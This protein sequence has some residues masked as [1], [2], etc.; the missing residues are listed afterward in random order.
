M[1]ACTHARIHYCHV[2]YIKFSF[3]IRIQCTVLPERTKKKKTKKAPCMEKNIWDERKFHKMRIQW[4]KIIGNYISDLSIVIVI[5]PRNCLS[6][7]TES[8]TFVFKTRMVCVYIHAQND[9]VFFP[10]YH[11]P[12]YF[13]S[14]AAHLMYS[15]FVC[16]YGAHGQKLWLRK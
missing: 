14:I 5:F 9:E 12:M 8:D 16:V 10:L 6:C 4:T 11:I 7:M 2:F 1:H 3:Q 13:V 15:S